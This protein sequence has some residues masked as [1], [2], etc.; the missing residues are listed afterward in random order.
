[1]RRYI[2]DDAGVRFDLWADREGRMMQMRHEG[3]GLRVERVFEPK[4]ATKPRR[5]GST[6]R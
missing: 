6:K 5:T 3:S 1:V 4:P 2:L